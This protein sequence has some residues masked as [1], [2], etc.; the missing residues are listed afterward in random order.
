M[1]FATCRSGNRRVSFD[2]EVFGGFC[3]DVEVNVYMSFAVD[4][5]V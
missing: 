5:L 4:G 1:P 2:V 3:G